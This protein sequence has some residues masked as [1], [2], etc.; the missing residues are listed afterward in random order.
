MPIT[1]ARY[2]LEICAS[3]GIAMMERFGVA[4]RVPPPLQ[5]S[6]ASIVGSLGMD[7]LD[8]TRNASY[9]AS[10]IRAP[11]A[12]MSS[13]G[14]SVDWNGPQ[15]TLVANNTMNPVRDFTTQTEYVEFDDSRQPNTWNDDSGRTNTGKDAPQKRA[16][17]NTMDSVPV[18]NNPPYTPRDLSDLPGSFPNINIMRPEGDSQRYLQDI[19]IDDSEDEMN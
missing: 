14:P 16:I 3:T 9:N 8:L 2:V 19:E 7:D 17:K 1:R 10:D 15:Q 18:F 6:N 4:D 5:T 11:R 13:S 12:E